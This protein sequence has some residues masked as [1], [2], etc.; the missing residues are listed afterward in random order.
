MKEAMP[1]VSMLKKKRLKSPVQLW[2]AQEECVHRG[3]QCEGMLQQ[4]KVH[5]LVWHGMEEVEEAGGRWAWV[6]EGMEATAQ[7]RW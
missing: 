5:R 7:M 4:V 1:H 6:C 3:R 2:E